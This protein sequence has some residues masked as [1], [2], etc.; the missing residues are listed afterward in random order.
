M[1]ENVE[2][3]LWIDSEKQASVPLFIW[4]HPAMVPLEFKIV[5]SSVRG[6]SKLWVLGNAFWYKFRFIFA[7]FPASCWQNY[8]L[9]AVPHSAWIS[10]LLQQ[11]GTF[12]IQTM[13]FFTNV[14]PE[15]QGREQ[16]RVKRLLP[17]HPQYWL[18]LVYGSLCQLAAAAMHRDLGSICH[19]CLT[20][21]LCTI[22]K[23]S[24]LLNLS[25]RMWSSLDIWNQCRRPLC[26]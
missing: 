2:L 3:F 9:Q 16:W 24:P 25:S 6:E 14:C 18:I 22:A 21:S 7:R 26:G 17:S 12:Y 19:H 15:W 5:K 10:T 1:S 23:P 20:V 8:V 4:S 13:P 11:I